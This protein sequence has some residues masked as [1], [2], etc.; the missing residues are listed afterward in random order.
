MV[1]RTGQEI[2]KVKSCKMCALQQKAPAESMLHSWKYPEKP[3]ERIHI[4]FA[5]YQ[6][7]QLLVIVDAYSKWPIVDV[8]SSTATSGVIDSLRSAFATYGLP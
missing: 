8:K 1:F 5:T 7:R 4:D 6:G 3:F 2:E